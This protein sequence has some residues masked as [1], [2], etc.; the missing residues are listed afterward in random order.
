MNENTPEVKYV[1]LINL[2]FCKGCSK[3]LGTC[4]HTKS[5]TYKIQKL[6]KSELRLM[7]RGESNGS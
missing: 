6:S 5:A 2:K 7:L 3:L 4:D 1:P